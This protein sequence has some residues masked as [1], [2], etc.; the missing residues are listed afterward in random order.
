LA[1]KQA[2]GRL[3]Q[4]L[5]RIFMVCTDFF[6]GKMAYSK[7]VFLNKWAI[8]TRQEALNTVHTSVILPQKW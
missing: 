7:K 1:E 6:G 5:R 8:G 3:Y 4:P 2:A